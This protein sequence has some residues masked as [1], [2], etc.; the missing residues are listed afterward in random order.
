MK[1]KTLL[2]LF[3]PVV[4]FVIGLL[5]WDYVVVGHFLKG[6]PQAVPIAAIVNE[7][8]SRFDFYIPHLSASLLRFIKGAITGGI[9]G[10][11]FGLFLG[12]TKSA[13]KIFSPILFFLA[14][15]PVIVWI[16]PLLASLGPGETFKISIV[17]LALFFITVFE[18]QK[19]V[20]LIPKKHIEAAKVLRLSNI[21]YQIWIIFKPIIPDALQ[22]I[23]FGLIIAWIALVVSEFSDKAYNGKGLG[24]VLMDAAR[25]GKWEQRYAAVFYLAI[26]SLLVGLIINALKNNSSKWKS[27]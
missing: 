16:P 4:P 7:A 14:V 18:T 19:A 2:Y 12:Q 17:A 27:I 8:L 6:Q 24:Y 13:N 25:F 20:S 3:M 15:I 11:I 21:K 22:S 1:I 9:F 10:M 5:L 26:S 23:S